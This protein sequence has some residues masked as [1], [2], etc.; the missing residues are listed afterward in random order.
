MDEN[1]FWDIIALFNWTKVGNDDAVLEPACKA[2]EALE[3]DE[4]FAFDNILAEKLHALDTREHCRDCYAGQLDPDNGNDYISADD[5]LYSRCVVVANGREAFAVALAN[6]TKMPRD[7]EFE[8]LLSLPASAYKRK[9]GEDYAHVT[10]I[11][12]E[13]FQNS[14]GW[15]PTKAT[16]E[17]RFT[18]QNVPPG[19]RRPT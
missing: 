14:A 2:L 11:S 3:E 6:P 5:F 8:A 1:K 18:G 15:E 17:G 12:Y 16:R 19:N 4:I 13:S 10:P 9:T 7:M